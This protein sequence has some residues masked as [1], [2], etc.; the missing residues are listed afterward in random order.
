MIDLLTFGET[1]V[2]FRASGP[3]VNG[4]PCTAH[5][6]GA[7]SNVAIALARLGHDVRW[8]GAL[9]DDALG[10]L[11]AS[12]IARE[13]VDVVRADPRG[14]PAGM[15]LLHRRTAD[16]ARVAYSRKDSAG[17]RLD[18]D[19]VLG[20]LGGGVRRLHV[21]G[22]TPALSP[23]TRAATLDAVH[24]AAGRGVLVSLDVNYRAA[25][26]SRGEARAVLGEVL[27][28]VEVVIASEDELDLV[29]A[30][31]GSEAEVVA[32]LAEVGCDQ[33]VVKRGARGA[34]LH[35]GGVRLDAAALPVSVVDVV[36]AGDALTA[37]YLSGRLDGLDDAGC[38]SRGVTL[39]AFAVSTSGDWEGLPR[40]GE[41]SLLAAGSTV[42]VAR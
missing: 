36:G 19:A 34:S 9:A 15:M 1:M 7:E 11:V 33:V 28:F 8:A 40:R 2:S 5:V 29:G 23:T 32:A 17:S 41:L 12:T 22:I 18:T 25:L 10:E 21:T 14:R 38:L 27:P 39:G 6:A 16:L 24:E 35:R 3:L 31:G 4:M 26:W 42:D 30:A 13:G 20:A 37:G